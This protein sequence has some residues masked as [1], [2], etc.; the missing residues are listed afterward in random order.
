MLCQ[1]RY[2]R[3]RAFNR[4]SGLTIANVWGTV[5]LDTTFGTNGFLNGTQAYT[6][7]CTQT[8]G[9]GL[10]VFKGSEVLD[11]GISGSGLI[12]RT[13]LDAMGSPYEQIATWVNDP[14]NGN[15]YTVHARLGNLNGIANC[16]GYGIYTDNGFFTGKIV[17][18][19]LTK[20]TNYLSFDTVN[21]LQVK[22]GGTSVATT[23]DVSNSLTTANTNAQGY[24]NTAQTTAIDTASSDATTKANTAYN[25]AITY[26]NTPLS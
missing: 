1:W 8:T 25:N 22:I 19:D 21:G 17:I 18:G 16:N 20:T 24:A 3:F 11:Y 26:T 10:T 6:F 2:I 7:T 15:N 4:T 5:V 9:V 12:A 14:S 23:T 13:T